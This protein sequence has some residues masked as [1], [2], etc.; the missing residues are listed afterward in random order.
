[1][2]KA[3]APP[4]EPTPSCRITVVRAAISPSLIA[5][6][7]RE[8]SAGILPL[9]WAELFSGQPLAG[10]ISCASVHERIHSSSSNFFEVGSFSFFKNMGCV[11]RNRHYSGKSPLAHLSSKQT[12]PLPSSCDGDDCVPMF[13]SFACG[14]R[15]TRGRQFDVR[16]RRDTRL[17]APLFPHGA[18]RCFV[19]STTP[20]NPRRPARAPWNQSCSPSAEPC[21]TPPTSPFM[22]LLIDPPAVKAQ[23]RLPRCSSLCGC[24]TRFLLLS[25]PERCCP[26]ILPTS[27]LTS[28]RL[29][30][31]KS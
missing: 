27:S 24:T 20:S 15:S 26:N 11:L 14:V 3:S 4:W 30:Q 22:S 23:A 19:P 8:T 7:R 29:P 31:P 16:Q 9:E 12:P 17:A 18:S 2:A 1:M 5:R 21:T 28:P 13:L 6:S 10:Q 25:G